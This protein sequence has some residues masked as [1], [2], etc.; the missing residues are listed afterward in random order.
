M[1]N[2]KEKINL[3]SI[4]KYLSTV[5]SWTIFTLLIMIIII[6][7]YYFIALQLYSHLGEKYAPKFSLYTIMS[8][9]MVPNIKKYDV[10]INTK[11]NSPEKLGINDVITFTSVSP[12]TKG[13]TITHRIVSIVNDED[14]ISFVTKGDANPIQ[15][16]TPVP[17]SNVI[18][19]V[20]LKIPRLGGIQVFVAQR[21]GWLLLFLFP[22]F[23]IL[24]KDPIKK[25]VYKGV[26]VDNYVTDKID[27]EI[28][29]E[30]IPEKRNILNE[31]IE[32]GENARVT[33]FNPD[34]KKLNGDNDDLE[35]P[36]LK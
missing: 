27:E 32:E 10:I 22:A 25:I 13:M 14:G 23:C 29:E 17:Y 28:Y 4:F 18:G 5:V 16:S 35:L 36:D 31:N 12:E 2:V 26:D 21:F 9:S 8:G 33:T 1:E 34:S 20:A 11:V 24:L 15:D 6:L 19:K 7:V 30:D 3:K